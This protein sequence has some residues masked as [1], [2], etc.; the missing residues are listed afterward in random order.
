MG[1]RPSARLQPPRSS[2]SR[3]GL[4]RAGVL[5][6]PGPVRAELGD[7]VAVAVHGLVFPGGVDEFAYQVG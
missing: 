1:N 2:D 7:G 4:D 5:A 3:S 6:D